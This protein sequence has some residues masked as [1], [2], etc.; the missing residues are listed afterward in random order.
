MTI[1][2]H[3]GS[4]AQ[5][6]RERGWMQF[7]TPENLAKARAGEVLELIQWLTP[8]QFSSLTRQPDEGN[9]LRH[10]LADVTAQ[11]L[12]LTGVTGIDLKEALAE[13]AELNRHPVDLAY[14]R[15]EKHTKLGE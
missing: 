2:D 8:E 11:L 3:Q 6:A 15:A 13:K 5:S 9:G 4:L 7:H 10:E 1:R 12:R 14:A